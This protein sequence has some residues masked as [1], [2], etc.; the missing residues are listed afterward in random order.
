MRRL[1]LPLRAR[2]TLAFAAAM[3]VV[4]TGVAAYV[5]VNLRSDLRASVDSGLQSRAQVIRANVARPAPAL[6]GGGHRRLIDPDEAF[7]QVLS[8]AGGIVESTPAVARAALV[9]R[10]DLAALTGP[11]FVDRRPPGL[12]LSRLLVVPVRDGGRREFVVVGATLSDSQEALDTALVRFAVAFPVALLLSSLIGWLLAGAALR[13]VE[14]MRREAAGISGSDPTGRL[15][16]PQT[17]D[18][19]ARLAVT[20]NRTF[21]RLQEAL[22]RERRFVDDASHELR[23]PLTILKAEVD[24]ALAGGRSEV[25]LRA[26][27]ASASSEVNHLVRI[28]EDLLVLARAEHGRIPVRREPVA[29]REVVEASRSALATTAAARGVTIE[30]EAPD[31]EAELDATRVRQALDN[32]VGNAIRHSPPGG[33]VRVIVVGGDD[34]VAISVEDSGPGFAAA[35]LEAVFQPFHRGRGAAHEG[36]G[37]GLAIVRAI[38]EAHEGTATAENRPGGGACVTLVL[39]TPQRTRSAALARAAYSTGAIQ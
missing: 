17:D 15:P 37:L 16:V 2:L 34:S 4:L 18:T 29:L 24:S 3:A 26:S 6:G 9:S 19:L 33:V 36:S 23:T 25:E 30:A 31:V 13:P 22:E 14:R 21:D 8:A 35:E 12:D 7:A 38:A 1:R 20:L 10:S 5:Y 28:A 39:K 32:L 27:L 11:R